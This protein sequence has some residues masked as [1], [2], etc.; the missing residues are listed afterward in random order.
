[1]LSRTEEFTVAR[2]AAAMSVDINGI[3]LM[4]TKEEP[5]LLEIETENHRYEIFYNL[6]NYWVKVI[7]D[8][9][10]LCNHGDSHL[11][12][13][14]HSMADSFDAIVEYENEEVTENG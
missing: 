12:A 1:M 11:I 6:A 2:I 4:V 8:E 3:E 7:H 9:E 5:Q 14:R 10:P 13:V